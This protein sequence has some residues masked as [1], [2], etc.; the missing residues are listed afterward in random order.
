MSYELRKGACELCDKQR[1]LALMDTLWM[2]EECET[3]YV[4]SLQDTEF[5]ESI[6]DFVDI[7]EYYDPDYIERYRGINYDA[8]ADEFYCGETR[9]LFG[10]PD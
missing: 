4:S 9:V 7:D 8:D 1:Q 3:D 2:C 10:F 6:D 5:E